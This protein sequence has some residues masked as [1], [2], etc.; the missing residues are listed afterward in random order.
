MSVA[1]FDQSCTLELAERYRDK[2]GDAVKSFRV[3]SD[4][5]HNY[6]WDEVKS[7]EFLD[8]IR[9]QLELEIAS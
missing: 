6:F 5:N 2:I 7:D 1:E 9:Y 4:K 8:E 3:L